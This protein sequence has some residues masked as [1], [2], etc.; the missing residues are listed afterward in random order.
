MIQLKALLW[1]ILIISSLAIFGQIRMLNKEINDI[2]VSTAISVGVNSEWITPAKR[3]A[4]V[5][6]SIPIIASWYSIEDCLGCRADR[7]MANG[8]ILK[9]DEFTCA[10]NYAALG[11]KLKLKYKNKEIICEVSDRIGIDDRIDLTPAAFNALA[12][13]ENGLIKIEIIKL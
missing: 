5:E 13:L 6:V 12:P 11:T 10:Y 8:K 2:A 4:H 1:T 9:D 7:I 3:T